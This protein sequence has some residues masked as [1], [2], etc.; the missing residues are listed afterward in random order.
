MGS[1]HN[2][3]TMVAFPISLNLLVDHEGIESHS[4]SDLSLLSLNWKKKV[5][6]IKI[7]LG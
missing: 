7:K 1:L 6:I 3:V 2:D 4:E 5:Y